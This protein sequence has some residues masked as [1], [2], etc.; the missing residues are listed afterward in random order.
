MARDK[1]S[2]S[3]SS[4]SV[5]TKQKSGLT[6]MAFRGVGNLIKLL[7][8]GTVFLFQFLS[9]ILTK[10]GH[11]DTINKY[12][13][14][15]LLGVCG[16][17]CFF[18][19]FTDSNMGSD[20]LVHYGIVTIHGLWSSSSTDASSYKLRVGDFVHGLMSLIVLAVVALLDPNTMKCYYPSFESTQKK[21]VMVLPP[22]VGAVASTVFVLFPSN[23]HGIGYPSSQTPA[24]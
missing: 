3:S 10:N 7:P 15:V 23:R 4:T 13:T 17:S 8:T 6:S 9:P 19:S 11:C 5:K 1:N 22:V 2:P 14:S 16:F 24:A 20:G 12:L 18:S 21:L